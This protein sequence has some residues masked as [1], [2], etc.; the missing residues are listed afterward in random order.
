VPARR[1]TQWP[2][3]DHYTV[4]GV[5]P[6]ASARQITSAYRRLVCTLHPDSHPRQPS[7]RERF[8]EVID[9]YAT[10]HDPAR[11][12]AHDAERERR[13]RRP[14]EGRPIQVKV[15][16]T[17]GTSAGSSTVTSRRDLAGV[18]GF[19]VTVGLFHPM[20]SVRGV[21]LW[22]GPVRR[23]PGHPAHGEAQGAIGLGGW[24][25]AWFRRTSGW[26]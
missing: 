4:L 2:W 1:D 18:A 15:T 19:D 22:A 9:A 23:Y 5:E 16:R 13:A 25:S 12:A 7:A 20:A 14:L 8:A 6:S 26:L 10:L 21:L 17:P 24:R 11:R 3:Q